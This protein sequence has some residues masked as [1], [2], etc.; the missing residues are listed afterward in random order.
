MV[1]PKKDLTGMVFGRLTVDRQTEDYIFPSGA[2]EAQWL[3]WCSCG[4]AEPV[5]ATGK[6]LKSGDKKS[7]GCL[8]HE[9]KNNFIDMTGWVMSEHGVPNSRL[10]VLRRVDD[11][12][13][14]KG[15]RLVQWECECLC[16]AHNHLNVI[17]SSIRDGGT[18]SCG[19]IHRERSSQM[20]KE[21]NVIKYENRFIDKGSYYEVYDNDN[22]MFIIDSDDKELVSK[23]Y[24]AK[25]ESNN[26]FKSSIN[27]KNVWLHRFLE[28]ARE[29]EYVDH[30]NNQF[31]D[32]RKSNLRICD[33]SENNR[34]VGLQKNNTSGVT[35]LSWDE[36]LGKWRVR[37]TIYGDSK[38]LGLFVNKEDAIIA[39][40][41]AEDKY[42]GDFSFRKSQ[43]DST[44]VQ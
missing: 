36:R 38:E 13:S 44:Y 42:F 40:I 35:G 14:P 2:R 41:E 20:C 18:L 33:N 5:L 37:L 1:R 34:N 21:R 12:V 26:Y 24:W 11:Y 29:G 6:G 43:E 28:N 4:N 7:C 10:K 25:Y 22:N 16:D 31:N 15:E 27:G 23:T 32:Y 3:C 30:K 8:I 17:G 9:I 39:R 19:C